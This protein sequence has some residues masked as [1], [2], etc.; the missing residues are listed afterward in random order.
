[1][2]VAPSPSEI[3]QRAVEEGRRRLEQ[4][5]LELVATGFI[6]GFTILFGIAGLAIVRGILEPESRALAE[7]AGALAF[8]I[9][10]VFL[11]VGRAELF[12]EGSVTSAGRAGI[13]A[14]LTRA[15]GRSTWEPSRSPLPNR[16]SRA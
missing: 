3:F 5:L 12:S 8:A 2:A 16:P 9:G 15:A 4:S 11:F 13:A 1:M 7:I 6:A 10:F 14:G